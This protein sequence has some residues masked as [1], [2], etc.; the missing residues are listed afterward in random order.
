MS[1]ALFVDRAA[2]FVDAGYVYAEGGKLCCGSPARSRVELN[3]EGL[4]DLLCRRADESGLP[5]LR[6]YWYDAA[7]DGIPTKSQKRIASL[8]NVKLR[9]GRLSAKNQQKGVDALI[10]RDL[11]T[12][13]RERAIVE[14]FLVSGDEDLREGVRAAQDQGV[15]VTVV[16]IQPAT[17]GSHNQSRGLIDEA[18]VMVQLTKEELSGLFTLVPEPPAQG[19]SSLDR[20]VIEREAT[21]FAREWVEQASDG[22]LT[23]LRDARPRI[24]GPLD[25]ELLHRL[26]ERCG[27][28]LHGDEGSRRTA[29]QAFWTVVGAAGSAAG[30][31]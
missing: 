5:V 24:P 4:N 26:Q 3:V 15:R 16:G 7:R 31:S 2:I 22:E 20:S 30:T 17:A 21:A 13:A 12:L 1:E 25:A 29:R 8:R 19:A 6:T 9:L 14:A 27:R 11:M 18:D 28:D 10:Y 23:A